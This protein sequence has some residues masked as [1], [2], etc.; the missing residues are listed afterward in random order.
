MSDP[1]PL[2]RRVL[3]RDFKRPNQINISYRF[4][5]RGINSP[6]AENANLA[7]PATGSPAMCP[8]PSGIFD[9]RCERLNDKNVLGELGVHTLFHLTDH[10]LL[11]YDSI[12]NARD[13]RFT[14]NRGGLKILS[15][16]ECWTVSFSI[17]SNRNPDKT[18]FKFGFNLLGLGS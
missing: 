3:D 13:A 18:T 9:S 17:R 14:S 4:V 6:F 16:C 12:Y 11:L 10:L 15:S 7:F 2:D 8:P 5:R 1:R